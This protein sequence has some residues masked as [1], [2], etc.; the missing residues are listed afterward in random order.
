MFYDNIAL[1]RLQLGRW[2]PYTR[3]QASAR[4]ASYAK[5]ARFTGNPQW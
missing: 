4:A 3:D 1:M 5:S 2:R